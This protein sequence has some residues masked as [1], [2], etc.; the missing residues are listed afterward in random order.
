MYQAR[1]RKGRVH[2]L[3]IAAIVTVHVSMVRRRRAIKTVSPNLKACRLE[4]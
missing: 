2:L 4:Q 1:Q 3:P